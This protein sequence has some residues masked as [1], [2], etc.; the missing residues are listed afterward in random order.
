MKT[1]YW[2]QKWSERCPNAFRLGRIAGEGNYA[3]LSCPDGESRHVRC[4]MSAGDRNRAASTWEK[5]GHCGLGDACVFD[6]VLL[7]IDDGCE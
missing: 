7:K 2:I 1:P 6:H 5:M 3:L 4:F